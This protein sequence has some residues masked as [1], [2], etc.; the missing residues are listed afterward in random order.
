MISIGLCYVK[1]IKIIKVQIKREVPVLRLGICSE[2][3]LNQPN[4]FTVCGSPVAK[5]ILPAKQFLKSIMP[6]VFVSV[7][8]G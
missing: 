5:G 8:L 4:S 1:E 2:M 7:C 3:L 6:S